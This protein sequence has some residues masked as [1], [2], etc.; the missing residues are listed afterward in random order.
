MFFS[1]QLFSMEWPFF[2]MKICGKIQNI[3][4]CSSNE[5]PESMFLRHNKKNNINSQLFP[6]YSVVFPCFHYADLST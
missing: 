3:H 4:C 2:R 5:Y 1:L 6:T